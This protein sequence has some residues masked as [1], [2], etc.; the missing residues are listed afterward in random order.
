[1][2]KLTK[3]MINLAS[4]ALNH[5]YAPYSNYAVG[6]C[7]CSEDDQLFTGV[8]VE[9][10]S[11]GLTIC[12]EASAICHMIMAG[13]HKIKSVVILNGENTLCPPCGACRQRL[14]EF[15][16]SKTKIYLCNQQTVLQEIS[17]GELLP[18]AFNL[19]PLS[20]KTHD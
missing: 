13:K 18:L 20:G 4:Q 3:A 17:M 5:V 16:T 6:A 11:Y 19:N 10:A 12:A 1:M 9:N 7:L 2:N 15:S 8:N 14:H